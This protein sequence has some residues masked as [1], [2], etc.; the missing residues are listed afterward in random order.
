V[1]AYEQGRF[2]GLAACSPREAG[3]PQTH[4]FDC[5]SELMVVARL[6]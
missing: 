4:D 5:Y 1:Y 6:K 3:V 2:A